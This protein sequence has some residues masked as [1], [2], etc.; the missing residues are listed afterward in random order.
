MEL[1]VKKLNPNVIVPSKKPGDSGYDL[2]V[3]PTFR[4]ALLEP[5]EIHMFPTDI[6]IEI[7]EGY[8]FIIKERGS[9]GSKGLAVRC[10]VVDA[11]YRGEIF[12]AINNTSDSPLYVYN[13]LLDK[14]DIDDIP[15]TTFSIDKALAQGLII[16]TENWEVVV[17]EELSSSDR[18]A[19]KLGSSKK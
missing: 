11:S 7:P 18:G 14:A 2:Y 1:K 16:K 10:G 15:Y 9:T 5:G 4:S 13:P 17:E 19:G 6:S 8:A 12:I 3:S